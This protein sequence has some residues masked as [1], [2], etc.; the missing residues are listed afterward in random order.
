MN[1]FW[2]SSDSD[3]SFRPFN[4]LTTHTHTQIDRR[5][6][7]LIQNN[8]QKQTNVRFI[9]VHNRHHYRHQRLSWRK[10]NP[11]MKLQTKT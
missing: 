9:R 8:K 1:Q 3:L 7:C 2:W 11:K 4:H 5:N 6:M 10:K